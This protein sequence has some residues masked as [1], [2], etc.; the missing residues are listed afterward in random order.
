MGWQITQVISPRHT[1]RVIPREA[2]GMLAQRYSETHGLDDGVPDSPWAVNLADDQ[3]RF[4]LLAFDLDAHRPDVT[5]AAHEDTA[6]LEKLLADLRIRAVTTASSGQADGGRHVWVALTEPISAA[7]ANALAQRLGALLPTLDKAPL[8]NATSGCVRP[9]GAPHR[10]GGSSTLLRGRIEWLTRPANTPQH[11][12]ALLDVLDAR[13]EE[14]P[15]VVASEDATLARLPKDGKG[16]PYL[17]GERRNLSPATKDAVQRAMGPG[18][19]A[20]AALW[21]IMLGCAAARWRFA[22]VIAHAGEPGFEHARTQRSVTGQA[23]IARPRTGPDSATAVMRRQWRK[24]CAHIARNPRRSD[25]GETWDRLAA[26]IADAV[27]SI[28]AAADATPG[29]WA[30]GH[31]PAARRAL[32]TLCAWALE[33]LTLR[34]DASVRHLGESATL[35][36][37]SARTA[38]W[39]LE[40]WGLVRHVSE[41]VGTRAA[42]WELVIHTHP[43]PALPHAVPGGVPPP[44]DATARVGWS[45]LRAI[46]RSRLLRLHHDAWTGR[47]LGLAAGNLWVNPKVVSESGT[48]RLT[49][50]GIRPT[51]TRQELDAWA[52]Q[53]RVDG[54]LDRRRVSHAIERL[55][56]RWWLDEVQRVRDQQRPESS[57]PRV[58]ESLGRYPRRGRTWRPNH[59]EAARTCAQAIVHRSTAAA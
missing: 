44:A 45:V 51:T 15:A 40:R 53:H 59:L 39:A 21:R 7:V 46:L 2:S 28:Q 5:E 27:E 23:R 11:V 57:S 19:D 17:S 54:T 50:G 6:T 55:Q 22:D 3:G 56:Y 16:H 1:V 52:K 24:A 4:H 35:S 34:L 41:S 31:G 26:P 12:A 48:R 18:D 13:I 33:G 9:P 10:A 14:L 25:H 29:R 30:E 36:H 47:G 32:D 8:C 49:T 20:S 43:I 42:T 37:E 38:L 58:L